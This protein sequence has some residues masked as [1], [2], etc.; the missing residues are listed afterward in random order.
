M[1][2]HWSQAS[3]RLNV[4]GLNGVAF[5]LTIPLLMMIQAS[6]IFGII[7]IVMWVYCIFFENYLKMPLRCSFAMFRTWITGNNKEP[8]N[9]NSSNSFL[10]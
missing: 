1:N 4:F 10:G 3:H 2:D 6:W 5:F 8:K 9:P 7:L